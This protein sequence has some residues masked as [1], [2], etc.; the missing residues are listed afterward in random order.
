[1]IKEAE[2]KAKEKMQKTLETLQYDYSTIKAGRANPRILDKITVDYYGTITPLNQMAA[3]T[4]PEPRILIVAP[5]DV[6][7]VKAVEKA[8]VGSDLGLNPS[9]DGKQIRLVIPQLTEERRKELVKMVQKN[10]ED[11]KVAMRNI[12]RSTIEDI[13]KAEKNKEITEDE[14]KLGEK[15][16]QKVLDEY[17]KNVDDVMKE[18][19]KE[20]MTV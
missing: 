7:S 5:W 19:E 2:D 20:I 14:V 1:M 6:T 4:A 18:K 15:N 3:I 9:N 12:R 11:S 8:I 13:K 10:A 16:V 17:I